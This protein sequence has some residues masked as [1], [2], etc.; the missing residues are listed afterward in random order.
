MLAGPPHPGRQP[1]HP[2]EQAEGGERGEGGEGRKL[3]V[4]P[5]L[6][7]RLVPQ[8][9][10]GQRQDPTTAVRPGLLVLQTTQTVSRCRC[11]VTISVITTGL[12]SQC[13][14]VMCIENTVL[15]LVLTNHYTK[16]NVLLLE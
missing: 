3:R 13:W 8:W 5:Q 12:S 11:L 9:K 10:A 14:P 7:R 16:D 1:R 6:A 15:V 2:G 4:P